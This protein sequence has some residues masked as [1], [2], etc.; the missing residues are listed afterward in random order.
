MHGNDLGAPNQSAFSGIHI[1][2]NF[3]RCRTK[4]TELSLPA[5]LDGSFWLPVQIRLAKFFENI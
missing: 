2:K 3:T 5:T 1:R 4:P